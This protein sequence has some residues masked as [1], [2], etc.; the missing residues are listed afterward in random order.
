[1]MIYILVILCITAAGR[2]NQMVKTDDVENA[3]AHF[4]IFLAVVLAIVFQSIL[5]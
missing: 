2:L 3:L 1:M 4:I 5:L